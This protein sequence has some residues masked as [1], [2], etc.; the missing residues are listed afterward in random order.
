MFI[1]C[2]RQCFAFYRQYF[3]TFWELLTSIPLGSSLACF[4]ACFWHAFENFDRLLVLHEADLGFLAFW[5][6]GFLAFWLFGF[7]AFWLFGFLAFWLFGALL[8]KILN[9]FQR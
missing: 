1:W 4:L 5:L 9:A 6:F 2:F 3:C 7:L 8:G